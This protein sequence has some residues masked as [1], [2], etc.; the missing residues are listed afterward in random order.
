MKRY[1]FALL[2]LGL[3][4]CATAQPVD[5]AIAKI[6]AY[7]I[8]C[9]VK[10]QC[11]LYMQ[12]AQI[13]IEQNSHYRLQVANDNVVTT[14]G[15]TD[16]LQMAYRVLRIPNADGSAHISVQASCGSDYCNP[17]VTEARAVLKNFIITGKGL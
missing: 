8:N 5:P 4:G 7:P 3:G 16:D 15:P 12:R 10:E 1:L 17:S 13:W 11:D 14:Y 6:A 9:T 2:A